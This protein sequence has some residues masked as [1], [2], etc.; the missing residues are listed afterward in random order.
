MLR[1]VRRRGHTTT[2]RVNPGIN[3]VGDVATWNPP[4]WTHWKTKLF[5]ALQHLRR[6]EE[7]RGKERGE[8]KKSKNVYFSEKYISASSESTNKSKTS[9]DSIWFY[10]TWVYTHMKTCMIQTHWE[11]EALNT[12]LR[13]GRKLKITQRQPFFLNRL[14]TTKKPQ[15]TQHP[16]TYTTDRFLTHFYRKLLLAVPHCPLMACCMCNPSADQCIPMCPVVWRNQ[17]EWSWS[18]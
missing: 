15:M 13:F 5:T 8:W 12:K 10:K 17:T 7:R 14:S 16:H 2:L 18:S 3:M 1:Q 9:I 4:H 6:W 11:V